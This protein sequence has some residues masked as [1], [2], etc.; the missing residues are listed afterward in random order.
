MWMMLAFYLIARPAT[1]STRL[2]YEYLPHYEHGSILVT[3]RN[4][5]AALKLVK[6]RD[7]VAVEPM[8]ST[9][10]LALFEKKLG[11][12]ENNGDIIKLAA[13]LDYMPLAIVQ[14]AAYVSRRAP[15]CSVEQ[16]LKEFKKSERKRTSLLNR[17]EGQLHELRRDGEVKNAIFVT[18]QISF[19]HILQTRPS[20]A[21]LLSL[22]SFFDPQGIP[23]KLV[24]SRAEQGDAKGDQKKR[25]ADD[26]DS[27]ASLSSSQ[28][29][30]SMDDFEDDVV[31]L[32]N[33][34]LI[35]VDTK[36]TTF[37]MHALVQLAT[38]E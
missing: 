2:I 8:D 30:T 38:R 25:D 24:Q 12:Q 3:S 33:F 19:E 1:P 29:S 23:E 5:E 15:R 31:A 7:I 37:E 22:M 34:Y 18:W 9:Q 6:Q 16:Y 11:V 26:W 17:D 4:K 14:A 35:S 21:D 13:A 32:R 36:G 27:D 20:A 10:A 28:S